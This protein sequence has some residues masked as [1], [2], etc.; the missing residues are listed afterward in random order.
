IIEVEAGM[1]W[2]Q[3]I[4][5]IQQQDSTWA[6]IQKPTGTDNISIAGSLSANVHGRGLQMKPI[7]QDVESFQLV[8]AD[9]SIRRCS[10]QENTELFNLAIGGYGLFGVIY[11]VRLRLTRKKWIQ[12]SVQRLS[13][14]EFMPW[15]QEK[16]SQGAIYGDFQFAIDNTSPDFLTTGI[17]SVYTPVTTPPP[18]TSQFYLSTREWGELVYWA[19]CDKTK[20]FETYAAHYQKT[21]GQIY[22]SDTHQ[23]STYLND[24]HHILDKQLGATCPGSEMITELYVP[25]ASLAAFILDVKTAFSSQPDI[26]II[27]GTI[28]LIEKDEE[29][30]LAWAKDTYACIIFNL[31]VDHTPEG[32]HTSAEAFCKLIDFALSYGG[33]YYLTYHRHARADQVIK[34]YPQFLAFLALKA[35]FDP[36]G[37]FQSQWYRHYQ[38]MFL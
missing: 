32:L 19:H 12:R 10:R 8:L 24:Y 4:Q 28:R 6:I 15:V 29:S 11:S 17:C 14:E 31:H 30:F 3:L 9:G 35:K 34:A 37:L 23:L 25:R 36:T 1:Q 16:I 13:I 2:P 22:A 5:A 27:Y 20:A 18:S 26:S 21:D 7:I 38:K 33:S